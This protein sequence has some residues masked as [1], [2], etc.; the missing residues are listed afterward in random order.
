MYS[1]IHYLHNPEVPIHSKIKVSLKAMNL[2]QNLRTKAL[3]VRI[4]REGKRSPAGGSFENGY[5]TTST[6]LF[7]GYAIVIDTVAPVIRPSAENNQS[8]TSLKFT[9]SD[10]FSGINTYR[11]EVNGQWALVEWDPKNKLMIYRFDKVAKSGKNSFTLFLEDEKG[12]KK[13]YSTTFMR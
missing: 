8:R 6:N 10:N 12:N 7:D 13:S 11:G 3:L 2:P 9:V 4:D 1:E 5:V